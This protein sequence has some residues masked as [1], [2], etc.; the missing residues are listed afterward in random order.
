MKRAQNILESGHI[1]VFYP[2]AK[3]TERI[4]TVE[5]GKGYNEYR[6]IRWP[7]FERVF[8]FRIY[9]DGARRDLC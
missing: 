8:G 4:F 3:N 7:S 5:F 9:D 1:T 2:N 6:L